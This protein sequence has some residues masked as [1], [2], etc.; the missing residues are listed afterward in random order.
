[1]SEKQDVI[2]VLSEVLS[3]E[4]TAINQY[5]LHSRMVGDWGFNKLAQTMKADSIS[6]MK[7]ADALIQRIL[8]LKG[9]PDMQKYMKIKIGNNI[10]EI[11]RFDL[12]LE[13]EAVDRL[14]R[15]IKIATDA[16]DNGSAELLKTILKDE[17][18]HIEQMEEFFGIIEKAGVEN[19][20]ASQI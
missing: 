3:A 2:E 1:M 4:L 7:H 17:E 19:F 6:E 18:E 15:G 9:I 14:N 12:N 11:L 16:G 5:F 20:L 13:I 10:E 8:Y